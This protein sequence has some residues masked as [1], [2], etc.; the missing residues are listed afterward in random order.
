MN[1]DRQ[2][3]LS[4]LGMEQTHHFRQGPESSRLA[5]LN[6]VSFI[7]EGDAMCAPGS[8]SFSLF[9]LST[10]FPDP[11][12]GTPGPVREPEHS[13]LP[14]QTDRKL[15]AQGTGEPTARNEAVCP[16]HPGTWESVL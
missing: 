7:C 11:Q 8:F 9:S 12:P 6:P 15:A 5:R 16:L 3:A 10:Q 14:A 13:W 2:N 4:L 1:Q